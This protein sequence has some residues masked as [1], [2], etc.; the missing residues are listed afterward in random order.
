[1]SA[2]ALSEVAVVVDP[3]DN[4]AV[5]KFGVEAGTIV[6][7]DGRRLEVQ[8]AIGPGHRFAIESI[9]AGAYVRQYGQPIG[10]SRGLEPGD[11]ITEST[12]S[13]DIPVVRDL[14]DDLHTPEPPYVADAEIGTFPGFLRPD[15]RTGT[16]N[17]LL[18]LPT[19]MCSSHEAMQIATIAEF[20]HW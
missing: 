17:F 4:C 5:V 9:P 15:G 18:V 6:E 16:R 10:T 12:M 13:N 7:L 3:A 1:M 2:V 19:S 11:A 8:D 14:P 20:Q